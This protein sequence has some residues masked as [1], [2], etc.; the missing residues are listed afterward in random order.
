[1]RIVVVVVLRIVVVVVVWIGM[2]TATKKTVPRIRDE[3][4]KDM[5]YVGSTKECGGIL[6]LVWVL[7]SPRKRSRRA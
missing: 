6:V 1:M 5:E 2:V 3:N 7:T 4:K